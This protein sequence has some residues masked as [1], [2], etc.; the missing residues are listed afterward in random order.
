MNY[1][2]LIAIAQ[3]KR[4]KRKIKYFVYNVFDNKRN[5]ALLFQYAGIT[6]HQIVRE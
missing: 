6:R 2:V 4:K 3:S 5:M 1:N